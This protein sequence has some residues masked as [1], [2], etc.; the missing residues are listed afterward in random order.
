[1]AVARRDGVRDGATALVVLRLG[2]ALYAAHAGDSRAVL[3]RDGLAYRL[4]ED[5]KPHLPQVLM[6]RHVNDCCCAVHDR[7]RGL[8]HV[9]CSF[10]CAAPT[11]V[12][13]RCQ[14]PLNTALF[15][16]CWWLCAASCPTLWIM[17]TFVFEPCVLCAP[18]EFGL[19]IGLRRKPLMSSLQT[20]PALGVW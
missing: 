5:H 15:A 1:M 11:C 3:C 12:C 7:A 9:C 16:L 14:S 10:C 17:T 13:T 18:L 19:W 6:T 4:T 2:A 20:C 8:C